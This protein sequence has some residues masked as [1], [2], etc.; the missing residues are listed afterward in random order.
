[1]DSPQTGVRTISAWS[2]SRLVEDYESCAYKAY[3]LYVEKRPKPERDDEKSQIAL[4]R[5]KTVHKG[6][7]DYVQ[8]ITA[9]VIPELER[10]AQKLNEYRALFEQ[11]K[12]EVEQDWAYDIDW[13]PTGWYDSNTW[14]RIKLD[15]FVKL[16]TTGIVDDWKTGK[17]FGNEVKHVQQG[18]LYG[19]GAFM[20]YPELEKIK[21]RFTYVDHPESTDT[22]REYTRA[23][24]MRML[25]SWNS[26]ALAMTTATSFPAKPSQIS[27]RFCPFS[28]NNGGDGSC[29]SGV[30][31]INKP[32][33]GKRH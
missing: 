20:R 7:E 27:C 6:A 26:R 25:P 31:V 30:E 28:P 23:V 15:T 14:A 2:F 18:Q 21:V 3:L 5:G 33:T 17:K 1:M 19:I 16:G 32:K 12:V 4:Q 11:G 24:L 13:S 29:P 10:R 22:E 9:D 8:G